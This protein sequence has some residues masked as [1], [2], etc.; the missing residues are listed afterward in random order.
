MEETKLDRIEYEESI[1]RSQ[2][3]LL[4]NKFTVARIII[5][6]IKS[7][8]LRKVQENSSIKKICL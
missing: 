8:V 1:G 5:I 7:K 2:K 6:K 3:E 4:D